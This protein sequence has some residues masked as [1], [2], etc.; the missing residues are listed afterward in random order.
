VEMGKADAL[1]NDIE[2]RTNIV[3]SVLAG[4]IDSAIDAVQKNYATVLEADDHLI[5]FKLRCRKFVELILETAEMKKKMKVIRTREA[6]KHKSTDIV[7][8][9]WTDEEMDMDIDEDVSLYPA[10]QTLPGHSFGHTISGSQSDNISAE[11]I[12]SQYESALNLAIVYGQ[13]L[14]NDYQS[15][16]RPELQQLFKKTFGIVAWEDPLEAGG[17]I[18]DLAGHDARV[19]LAHELNQAILRSQGRPAQPALETLYRHVAVCVTQLG[20]SG[21]GAAAFADMPR[22]FLESS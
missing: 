15:D 14:S 21:V 9:T 5:L 4:D 7:Q 3:N 20:L 18:A 19:A 12:A 10:S 2:C 17:P 8:N 11:D 13:K 6:E 1:E 22:E 16:P